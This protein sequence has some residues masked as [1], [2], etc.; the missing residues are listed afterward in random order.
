MYR[1]ELAERSKYRNKP[2]AAAMC[3]LTF[4]TNE[5]SKSSNAR[6]EAMQMH[7]TK[8]SFEAVYL[9]NTEAGTA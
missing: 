3:A 5:F 6:V 7:H 4:I 8:V 1:W 2:P 9:Q